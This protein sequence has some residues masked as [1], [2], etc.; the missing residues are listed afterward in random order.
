MN[1]YDVRSSESKE[2][3]A[4]EGGRLRRF[5]AFG[6]E[7]LLRW[8]QEYDCRQD[9]V[10]HNPCKAFCFFCGREVAVFPNVLKRDF[11]ND[12]DGGQTVCGRN[13]PVEMA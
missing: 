9:F 2:D 6:M 11:D 12:S 5:C 1:E 8:L 13:F 7:P 10:G 3:Y 4:V